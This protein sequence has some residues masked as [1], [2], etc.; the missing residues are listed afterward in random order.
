MADRTRKRR[1]R[2]RT[3]GNGERL[4]DRHAKSHNEQG[5][6]NA[7]PARTDKT[8]DAAKNEHGQEKHTYPPT[9]TKGAAEQLP[10]RRMV[11]PMGF[12]PMNPP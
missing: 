4:M 6:D 2:H 9:Y 11:T 12:E 3:E 8:D 10:N 5:D 1:E 7:A